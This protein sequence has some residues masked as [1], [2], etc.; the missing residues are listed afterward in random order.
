[1][2]KTS[3]HVLKYRLCVCVM[4]VTLSLSQTLICRIMTWSLLGLLSSL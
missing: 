3:V 2:Q 1:M 4:S